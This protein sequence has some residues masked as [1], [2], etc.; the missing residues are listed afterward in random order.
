[1]FLFLFFLFYHMLISLFS[2]DNCFNL[3]LSTKQKSKTCFGNS[4]LSNEKLSRSSQVSTFKRK[5]K[6]GVKEEE[7]RKKKKF[8][9]FF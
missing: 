5:K 8:E 4:K 1:M 6:K 9:M 7:L 2:S 3:I